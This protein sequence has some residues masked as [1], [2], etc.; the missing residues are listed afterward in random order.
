MKY[1]I[2]IITICLI[3]AMFCRAADSNVYIADDYPVTVDMLKGYG[4]PI[5]RNN[6]VSFDKVSL[7]GL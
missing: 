5:K 3:T 7:R 2:L 4:D 6:I 1:R